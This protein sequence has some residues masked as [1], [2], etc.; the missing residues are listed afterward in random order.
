[1]QTP[2]PPDPVMDPD[3]LALLAVQQHLRDMGF[4]SGTYLDQGAFDASK[5]SILGSREL[6][7]IKDC[8]T[9]RPALAETSVDNICHPSAAALQSIEHQTQ[10]KFLDS[11][12]PRGSMLLEVRMHA[13][14]DRQCARSAGCN[15]LPDMPR[16]AAMP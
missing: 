13:W 9:M 12:L 8:R 4:S 15:I 2:V 10:R 6:L 5:A 7:H 3:E 14:T 16:K 11:K 1:M